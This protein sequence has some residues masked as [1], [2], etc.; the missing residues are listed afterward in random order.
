[1]CPQIYTP[2]LSNIF[3]QFKEKILYLEIMGM[4]SGQAVSQNPS[5]HTTSLHSIIEIITFLPSKRI[6]QKDL[7]RIFGTCPQILKS[8][9]TIDLNQ[10]FNF[11]SYDLKARKEKSRKVINKCPRMLISSARDQHKPTLFYPVLRCPRLFTFSMRTISS[12]N[13]SVLTRK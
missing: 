13:L 9:I 1:M 6:H 2:T 4:D 10:V 5:W 7:G 8:D 3:L 11:L 12:L